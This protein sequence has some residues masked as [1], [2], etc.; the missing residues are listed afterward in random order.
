MNEFHYFPTAIYREEKPEWVEHV[1]KHAE[2][3]YAQ[4]KI[5]HKRCGI[6]IPVIQTTCMRHDPEL[7]FLSDY[8]AKVAK[9]ILE[10]QGYF[11]NNVDLFT[12]GMWAQEILFNGMHEPHT[13]A[14]TQ[15]CGMLFLTTPENGAFPIFSDPR[16]GKLMTD[17]MM[18][19]NS[20]KVGTPKIYFN[21]VVPGTFM[22]FNAWVPHQLTI[23]TSQQST[24]FVHFTLGYKERCH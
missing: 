17:F 9:D 14:N 24:K 2:K 22:F 1:L 13:H 8:F 16:P 19:D 11:L 12:S 18:V 20:V 4:Q 3:F 23:N 5:E 15:M 6:E 7:F 10:K 21:N